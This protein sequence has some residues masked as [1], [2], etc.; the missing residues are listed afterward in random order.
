MNVNARIFSSQRTERQ[1]KLRSYALRLKSEGSSRRSDFI[2]HK[3][4]VKLQ[5]QFAL[6]VF[7]WD[8]GWTDRMTPFGCV[9]DHQEGWETILTRTTADGLE[10]RSRL[11]H[12]PGLTDSN[13]GLETP[14]YSSKIGGSLCRAY[15]INKS[16]SNTISLTSTRDVYNVYFEAQSEMF[17]ASPREGS[18][19]VNNIERW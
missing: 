7:S 18:P 12:K 6:K 15:E 3:R 5:L 19:K 16:T 10:W 14:T 8:M 4:F 13:G 1:E 17:W 2:S 9:N 11:W